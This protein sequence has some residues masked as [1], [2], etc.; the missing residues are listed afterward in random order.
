MRDF[1]I[2]EAAFI[3]SRSP[4]RHL[5][6]VQSLQSGIHFT[7]RKRL[8]G[9][10]KRLEKKMNTQLFPVSLRAV[11]LSNGTRE[12]CEVRTSLHLGSRAAKI[13]YRINSLADVLQRS[14]S[15]TS[16]QM[17]AQAYKK[18]ITLS[19]DDKIK[20]TALSNRM[21]CFPLIRGSSISPMFVYTRRKAKDSHQPFEPLF[22]KPFT[23]HPAFFPPLSR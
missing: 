15:A 16:R 20:I 13:I 4:A 12:Q 21:K 14:D 7:H 23:V 6:T 8:A 3:S 18:V 19:S 2:R 9:F 5:W 22:S 11:K 1:I 17:L 10:P